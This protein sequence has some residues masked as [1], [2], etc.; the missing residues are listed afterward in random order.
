M[1][2]WVGLPVICLLILSAAVVG[3]VPLGSSVSAQEVSLV[4]AG[5]A[6]GVVEAAI[7]VSR[8]T[9]LDAGADRVV[10][11]RDDVFADNPAGA[12]LA[13]TTGP[14]LFTPGGPEADLPRS[15][16]AEIRR[17]LGEGTGCCPARRPG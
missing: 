7:D 2:R 5:D 6:T 14:L 17:A 10:L 3:P 11:G 15:V 1:S 8:E 16:P 12:S 13:G 4:R 9:F